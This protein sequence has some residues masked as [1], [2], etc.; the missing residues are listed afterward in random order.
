MLIKSLVSKIYSFLREVMTKNDFVC[1]CGDVAE[2]IEGAQG[3][4]YTQY[5]AVFD[6]VRG[7]VNANEMEFVFG[8]CP[9]D[10]AMDAFYEERRYILVHYFKCVQCERVFFLGAC[11]RGCPILE[12]NAELPDKAVLE[13]RYY[14]GYGTM[15]DA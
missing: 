1:E 15:Y 4:E 10:E 12:T 8:S 2:A 13:R 9:I 11:I 7:K 5:F 6:L 3:G 14:G